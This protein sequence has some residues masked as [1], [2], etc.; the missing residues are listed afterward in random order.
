MMD[1]PPDMQERVVCSIIAAVKYEVPANILLAIAEKEGGKPGQWVRNSNGTHDVGS[2]QFNTAYLEDL[3]KYGITADHV[4]N[5]GCYAYD[6]A[7]WRIR[8][9]IQNDK[10]D[11]WTKAANYHSKTP[12]HNARY[13][14][15]LIVKAVKWADWLEKTVSIV[16]IK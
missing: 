15:D 11:I 2:M 14:A 4:A 3:S 10:G 5:T 1:L 16:E 7:A 13:R 12:A 8:Q 9:H 6:L